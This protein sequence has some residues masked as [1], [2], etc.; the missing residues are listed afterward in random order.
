M[1]QAGNGRAGDAQ[2][3]RRGRIQGERSA[4]FIREQWQGLTALKRSELL[5]E[6]R[7]AAIVGRAEQE[8]H[9]HH[10]GTWVL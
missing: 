4:P 5:I 1:Q 8:A 2:K 9:P 10:N 7:S 3:S 6:K